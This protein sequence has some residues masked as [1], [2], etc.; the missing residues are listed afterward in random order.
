MNITLNLKF[1]IVYLLTGTSKFGMLFYIW[2]IF[3]NSMLGWMASSLHIYY[4]SLIECKGVK[5]NVIF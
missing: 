4:F 5:K 2:Y 1:Y 3:E